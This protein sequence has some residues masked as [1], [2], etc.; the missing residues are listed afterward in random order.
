MKILKLLEL[1]PLPSG[2]KV[3]GMDEINLMGRATEKLPNTLGRKD[4]VGGMRREDWL[5]G[6]GLGETWKTVF[7]GEW[8]GDKQGR[9]LK[10]TLCNTEEWKA[11]CMVDWEEEG[12]T[13]H[14]YRTKGSE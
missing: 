10:N 4:L 5:V 11:K 8:K 13:D 2:R 6:T 1:V 3:K 9:L 12:D 7:Q 14:I